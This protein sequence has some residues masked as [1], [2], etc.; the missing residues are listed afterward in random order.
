M[1]AKTLV[2]PEEIRRACQVYCDIYEPSQ[3]AVRFGKRVRVGKG[4]RG[5][6]ME[7]A[8]ND[9]LARREGKTV[10]RR[11]VPAAS[12]LSAPREQKSND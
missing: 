7:A 11:R 10:A 1:T 3:Q 6:A 2:S 4:N 8:I 5:M 9:L 12:R